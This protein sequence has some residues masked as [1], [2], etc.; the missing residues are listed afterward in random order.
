MTIQPRLAHYVGLSWAIFL[1]AF[2]FAAGHLPQ[3]LLSNELP[4][5]VA[6]AYT[7]LLD[8]GLIAGYLWRRE[9]SLLLLALLHLFA[10]PRFG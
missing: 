8:N 5:S 1:Q 2:L 4:L 6:I 7:L 9:R 3:K 10:F